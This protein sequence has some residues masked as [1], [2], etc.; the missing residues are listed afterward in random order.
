MKGLLDSALIQNL[1][2]GK[3]PEV[4]VSVPQQTLV[5]I[6]ILAF[7]VAAAILLLQG[8]IKKL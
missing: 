4:S 5:N 2:D 6:G 8:I 1:K 7:I 3:L